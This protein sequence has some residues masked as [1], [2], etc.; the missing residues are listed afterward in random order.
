LDWCDDRNG[1]VETIDVYTKKKCFEI[2]LCTVQLATVLTLE[3]RYNL[4]SQL[5]DKLI[6]S[7]LGA[8]IKGMTTEIPSGCYKSLRSN[9]YTSYCFWL[10]DKLI[11]A[12]IGAK[13]IGITTE[14]PLIA[15]R[16]P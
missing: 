6:S 14:I 2:A 13:I 15:S 8:G 7:S 11:S 9:L 16:L 12:S 1:Q 5:F 3:F 4:L 10:F